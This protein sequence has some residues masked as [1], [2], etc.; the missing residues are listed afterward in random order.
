MF[1]SNAW[2]HAYK[3]IATDASNHVVGTQACSQR[4]RHGDEQCVPSSVARGVVGRFEP[5]YVDIG[6]HE[7]SADALRPID[8]APDGSQ[9]GA[10]AARSCQLVGLGIFTVLGG[11][12]AIFGCKLAVVDGLGAVVRSL[13]APRGGLSTFVCRILTVAR[14]AVHCGSVEITRRVV[15]R[16]GLSVTQPGRDVTVPRSQPG[17]PTAHRR[18]LVGPGIFAILGGLCPI[19]GC[20]LAVVDGSYAAVRSLSAPRVGPGTFVC[21]AQ[22]VA[23]R[24][25]PCGSVAITRRVVTRFGLSVTQPGRDVTVPRSQPGLPT[26]HCRQLVGPGILA[27]LGGLCAIVRCNLAIVDGSYAAVRSLSAPRGG[28]GTFVCRAPTIARRAIPC[29]SVEITRR[30]VTRFGLSVALLG[31]EVT[32]PRSQ[33]G[34]FA[35]LGGLCAIFGCK[36]AVVDGLGAVV[37]SL[38]APRGGLSTFVCRILTVARRAVPCGSVEITRRVVT[39]F[40]LSVT[41]PGRDVTVLRS[42]PGLP[43]AYSC[44]LVGPGIFAVL[45]GLRA[46]CGCNLA[47]VDGLGAVVRSPS[48]PRGGLGTF[49]CRILTF[50]RRAIPCGSVEIT[51]RVV[52]RFGL[53]VTQPGR[54]VTVLRS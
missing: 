22:T 19:F 16:F 8:L 3:L 36:L 21:R 9:P 49:V 54:D 38:S 2:E 31:R 39:R 24:A 47:I 5:V 6:S 53:S 29:G 27:V 32:R 26:T 51:R 34:I 23:R 28:P 18:Q 35:I 46:I 14:R 12:C 52:T 41:Q 17:L 33:R 13:S 45:G 30:V 1:D 25:I 37:R 44:Q 40:G 48:A 10:P 42:Q 15:T 50:A 43:A 4:V 7:L 20:N 11:P